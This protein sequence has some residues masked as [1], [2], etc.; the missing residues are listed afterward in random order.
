VTVGDGVELD[1]G[2][3]VPVPEE[4]SEADGVKL[5]DGV[6]LIERVTDADADEVLE[7]VPD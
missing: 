6:A 2:V 1:D 5:P 7:V 3:P 4:V